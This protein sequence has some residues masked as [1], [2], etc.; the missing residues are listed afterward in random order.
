MATEGQKYEVNW[1][2]RDKVT[3]LAISRDAALKRRGDRWAAP[4]EGTDKARVKKMRAE[5]IVRTGAAS[6]IDNPGA[7]DSLNT[8]HMRKQ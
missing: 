7:P 8:N 3:R 1:P 4:A 2:L 6:V 5:A